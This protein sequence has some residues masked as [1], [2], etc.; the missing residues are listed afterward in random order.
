M[1]GSERLDAA[2]ISFWLF[3]VEGNS[4][5]WRHRQR[6]SPPF[7]FSL[8]NSDR[9]RP[10]SVASACLVRNDASRQCDARTSKD[11]FCYCGSI[12]TLK[13]LE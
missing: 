5:K 9:H 13:P 6:T 11:L 1:R 4:W 8:E 3:G 2:D 12:Q 10:E 7:T